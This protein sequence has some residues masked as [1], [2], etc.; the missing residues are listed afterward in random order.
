MNPIT[1]L[2][3]LIDFADYNAASSATR[4]FNSTSEA[5]NY[6]LENA[7]SSGSAGA[8]RGVLNSGN[9]A[10]SPAGKIVEFQPRLTGG[11]EV[12]IDVANV[13][14]TG[15]QVA[16]ETGSASLVG[17]SLI[18][19]LGGIFAGLGVGILSYE[20]NKDFWV[21][22]SNNLFLN[23]PGYEP[24]TY[25][26]IEDMSILT[27]FKD[28]KTYVDADLIQSINNYLIQKGYLDEE[29]EI[30]ID[31]PTQ[32]GQYEF[33][34][35][36]MSVSEIE[37]L[38]NKLI[39][40]TSALSGYG[41][42]IARKALILA[43][44]EWAMYYPLY[45]TMNSYN[46]QIGIAG[47]GHI[48]SPDT[49]GNITITISGYIDDLPLERTLSVG[50]IKTGYANIP[51]SS[52]SSILTCYG[53]YIGSINNALSQ[54]QRHST[55]VSISQ[56]V[57]GMTDYAITSFNNNI[58]I[59]PAVPELVPL[60]PRIISTTPDRIPTEL[61]DW[62][63]NILEIGVI[64]PATGTIQLPKYLP[65]SIPSTSPLTNPVTN[66][67]AQI[68]TGNVPDTNPTPVGNSTFPLVNPINSPWSMPDNPSSNPSGNTPVVPTIP[69]IGGNANALFTVY[70][71]TKS[72]LDQLGGV[73]WQS[74]IIQQ[75]V[76]MFTN[77]P[78]DAIISL[79][80]VYVSPETGNSRNIKLGYIDSG[81]SALEVT[82]QYVE[83][84]CGT[85]RVPEYF[86]DCRDYPPYT[87]LEIY[88][89]MIGM[90]QVRVEDIVGC[91]VGIKYIVDVYTGTCLCNIQVTK[92]G[93]TQVL[94]TYEGNCA[95]NLP[96]TGADKS[97]Q[98]ASIAGLIGGVVSGNPILTMSGAQSII[99][100]GMKSDISHSG[101][102]S[103]NA[104]AMGI[105]KPYIVINTAI[106]A[107][108]NFSDMT[109]YSANAR[110][111][112][113]DISGYTR[114]KDINIS[115]LSLTDAEQEELRRILQEGVI[116]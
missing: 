85:V 65:V 94:Y 13:T 52:K 56:R 2:Q 40:N 68:Q 20:A 28:G 102:F 101:A 43:M 35:S 36:T 98:L 44:A 75:I 16:V 37:S 57:V 89:P 109:G 46:I 82:D 112:L 50:D 4:Y 116:L 38:A 103:G 63:Q 93:V 54:S 83:V 8:V 5:Y 84:D 48:S 41:G 73:L 6:L 71:P 11:T 106:P 61:P 30:S 34:S 86:G 92:Q 99:S 3:T 9:P 62:W 97:R 53:N 45:T 10:T 49:N 80:K 111:K 39:S 110:V 32:A 31:I 91:I 114:I 77:N 58:E 18:E 51:S 15:T 104:G 64:D 78:M 107:D 72:Q 88:L 81:V 23:V 96:L 115:G 7:Y 76:Q 33:N 55:N 66:P 14:D 113:G 74:S 21:D 26:N 87:T 70:N 47:S 105:K 25:D 79:H 22:I 67:Q 19:V 59:I 108:V 1:N 24:I 12:G 29:I 60:E 90:R 27:L 42:D 17:V 95:V 69:V 100:G